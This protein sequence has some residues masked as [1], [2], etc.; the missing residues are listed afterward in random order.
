MIYVCPVKG[1]GALHE[2]G[3]DHLNEPCISCWQRGWRTDCFGNTDQQPRGTGADEIATWARAEVEH[4][5]QRGR[6]VD[7]IAGG[8]A[9]LLL[10]LG[11]FLALHL[12]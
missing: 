9:F 2:M 6:L 10:I 7:E 3:S 11:G 1:C 8:V 12:A 4:A 5:D